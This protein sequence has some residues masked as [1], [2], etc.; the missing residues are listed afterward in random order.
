MVLLAAGHG[1][2]A[3]RHQHHTGGQGHA[4]QHVEHD[5]SVHRGVLQQAVFQHVQREINSRELDPAG[6]GVFTTGRF[7]AGK[8][9]NV[10]PDK[11]CIRDRIYGLNIVTVPTNRPKQRIDYPDAIYKTVNGKYRAVI[12]QV[13]ECHKNG[14]PVL[15]GTVSVAK[16]ETLAQLPD[17]A[18]EF[19]GHGGIGLT[20]VAHHGVHHLVGRRPQSKGL[21]LIH[22]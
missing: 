4:G 20:V 5:R 15:V 17:A 12:E 10:I 2:A 22:I 14:Q 21:S 1:D 9:S 7:E 11:M 13:L 8:A 16:S 18:D 19:R 6:F 3:A